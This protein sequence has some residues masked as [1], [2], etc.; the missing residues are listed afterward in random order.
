MPLRIH[1][2]TTILQ[3]LYRPLVRRSARQIVQGRWLDPDAPQRG[4]WSAPEVDAYLEEVWTRVDELVPE[5]NLDEL[6]TWG[7]RHNVYLAVVTT[8][9]YQ[10][11][12]EHGCN[13][14]WAMELVGDMGWKVYRWLLK[15]VVE[16]IRL[17]S[18]DTATTIRRTL[19]A[20]MVFPFNAPGAPGYEVEAWSEGDRYYT[21]WRHC[22]PEAFVRRLV[23]EGE[24]RGELEAFARSWCRYDWAAA[25]EFAADGRRGH[26]ERSHTLSR[27]D[28]VCDMCWHAHPCADDA[29][30]ETAKRPES[31]A[32]C[33]RAGAIESSKSR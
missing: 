18:P 9:A 13:R 3:T 2:F 21:Y 24:D 4:R 1:A 23:E 15:A 22:P 25:D 6:P 20:L 8:A 32:T 11:L 10:V 5:A 17:T 27:G 16:P 33:D 29:S 31:V 14:E 7:N 12:L 26:Y 28:D 19:N 30:N